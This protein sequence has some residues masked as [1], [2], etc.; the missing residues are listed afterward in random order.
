LQGV[1]GA[2]FHSTLSALRQHGGSVGA[3]L[4][5]AFEWFP[6]RKGHWTIRALLQNSAALAG[7]AYSFRQWL[8]RECAELGTTEFPP[9]DFLRRV[10]GDGADAPVSLEEALR[11]RVEG[12]F[13]MVGPALS[14]Y[15]ICD[16][17]LWLWNEGRTGVFAM[18][19][20]D[21]FHDQFVA[22]YGRGLLPAD[23][24]SFTGWWFSMYADV[25]PRL[26]N[27]CIWLGTESGTV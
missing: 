2:P 20:Q 12:A 4:A 5:D 9:A 17:Q 21:S 11:R 3:S 7:S 22:R 27:E 1:R 6:W 8:R 16:W 24:P 25:P 15:M 13:Y 19:K 14:A 10:D 23:R 18:Y 26:V